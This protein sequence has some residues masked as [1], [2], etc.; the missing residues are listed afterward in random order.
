MPLGGDL[1]LDQRGVV[2]DAVRLLQAAVDVI[3][4]SG[5]LQPALAAMEL[6]QMVAQ[7]MGA[8]DSVLLQVGGWGCGLL[9]LLGL[10]TAGAVGAGPGCAW[11]VPPGRAWVASRAAWCAARAAK[12][13]R[14]FTP[15]PP[16]RHPPT[17]L[18]PTSTTAQLPHF[19][20]ELAAKCAGAGVEHVFDLLEL[21]DEARRE[22]L[23]MSEGQLQDVARFCNRCGGG[24]G[25][26]R[27]EGRGPGCDVGCGLA[28]WCF[29]S[30]S[31]SDPAIHH[32]TQHNTTHPQLTTTTPTHPH[33][34]TP[35]HHTH[36]CQ[37]PGHHARVRGGGRARGGGGRRGDAAGVAAARGGGRR[38]AGHRAALPRPQ[39]GVV[40][41]RGA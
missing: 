28:G 24:G 2:R 15:H 4:T 18:S 6:S 26:G 41:A 40:V 33:T 32:T 21:E 3:A 12:A 25:G 30:A 19:S 5:W 17:H 7:G 29:R 10:W 22:L 36:P 1:A 13:P 16:T 11:A 31:T 27:V 37:V 35:H 23:G 34:H 39:G 20:G 9:G 14:P 38:G 8:K